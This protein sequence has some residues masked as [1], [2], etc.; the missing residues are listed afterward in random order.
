MASS[1][2]GSSV[3]HSVAVATDPQ[4]A[5][6]DVDFCMKGTSGLAVR[7]L[8]RR[9][10]EESHENIG[11]GDVVR[12]MPRERPMKRSRGFASEDFADET[13]RWIRAA[14]KTAA[15]CFS[16]GPASICRRLEKQSDEKLRSVLQSCSQ[17]RSKGD[18]VETLQWLEAFIVALLARRFEV[19]GRENSD[20]CASVPTSPRVE[21]AAPRKQLL[22]ISAGRAAAAAGI[23][24]YA[25][26]GELFLELVYQDL[27]KLLLK[28]CALVGVELVSAV[29]ER[30]QLMAKSGQA[31]A[32][33][34]AIQKGSEASDVEAIRAAK[35]AVSESLEAAQRAQRISV[36]EMDELRSTLEKEISCEFGSKHEDA[37]MAAYE[38]RVGQRVYGC[39]HRIKAPMPFGGP[40]EAL[41]LA[42]PPTGSCNMAAIESAAAA[43]VTRKGVATAAAAAAVAASEIEGDAS[44]VIDCKV[45]TRS[46]NSTLDKHACNHNAAISR[47]ACDH[48]SESSCAKVTATAA[49]FQPYFYLTG[50]TDGIVDLPRDVTNDEAGL[51]TLVVEV[52]HRLGR[53]QE[54]PNIY[55]VVQLCSYCR[56]LGCARGELVQCLRDTPGKGG[57]N[58][59]ELH[60]M[61]LDFSE[62]TP[63]RIGWDKHV[64]P[65]LYEIARAVYAARDDEGTRYRLL[66]S[67]PEERKEFVGELCPHLAT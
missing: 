41:A 33:E 24:P 14:P 34:D 49:A 17:R 64:L 28:D 48:S 35:R 55:D 25:N 52:K 12:E 42:L 19:R 27:P 44:A 16:A 21:D 11:D 43:R 58:V 46:E 29:D 60:I 23:H 10:C 13:R 67:S 63:H 30:T 32:L 26:I 39:Q 62:G 15:R 5:A 51:E 8:Q 59:G 54:N 1:A 36:A 57:G 47:G 40:S 9:C 20:T 6:Q 56:V 45:S 22:R 37:A 31:A 18:E 66:A 53:I 2:D 38:E 7:S 3:S 61:R 4:G 65:G 50:F